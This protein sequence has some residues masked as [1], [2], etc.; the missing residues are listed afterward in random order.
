VV[1]FSYPAELD[2]KIPVRKEKHGTD[3]SPLI[4]SEKQYIKNTWTK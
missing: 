2:L 4:L 1:V 3:L